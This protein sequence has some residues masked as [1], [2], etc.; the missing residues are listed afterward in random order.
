VRIL[1]LN[2]Y[3]HPDQ[4]ATSQLLTELCEDL[5]AS[6]EVTVVTG[7][8]SYSPTAASGSHGL[9]SREQ[10][11]RVRVLRVWSTS[12]DRSRGMPGR[13]TNYASYVAT[14][15]VGAV[16]AAKPD[17]VVALTDPPLIGLVGAGAARIRRVP[18]V[19][20]TKDIFPDVA[21][22]LGALRSPALIRSLRLVSRT[23]F[24]DAARVVAIGR[25][26]QG[27]LQE[28][29]LSPDRIV[30]IHDW[31]DGRVV[32]PVEGPSR[33]RRERGWDR[34]V[35]MHSG[36][37]GLSQSLD[38]LIGAA[39]LLR[40]RE[41]ILFAIVGEGASK[42]RLTRRV[43]AAGL[44]NVEFL[45]YQ[46]KESLADS[47]GAAD[48]H[49]IGLRRGLPG[50]IVPSKLYGIMAAGKAYVAAV[51]PGS[52]PALV[53]EEHGCGIVVEP[54]DPRAVADAIVRSREMPLDKMGRRGRQAF[55]RLYDRPIATAKYRELLEQVVAEARS[56]S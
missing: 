41:D 45:P 18:F 23:L 47:L 37:V 28:H 5:S 11:G 43:R 19:L 3:F 20:V 16:A 15:V 8:P 34:F 39:E 2:Q 35:V 10:H 29:G 32:V 44:A 17:V 56:G 49:V 7:R 38:T 6:H 31:S 51:E 22:Q 12:F 9:I 46:P 30:T 26:M 25:D 52:E 27:R 50:Y 14:S 36:N 48:L 42:E 53:A 54:D 13:L 21:I 4:S 33:L 24:H 40:G 55:E 1:V